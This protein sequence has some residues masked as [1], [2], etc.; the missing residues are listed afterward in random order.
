MTGGIIIG[1]NLQLEIDSCKEKI[2]LNSI[3]F[4]SSLPCRTLNCKS[5]FD[6]TVS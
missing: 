5:V 3:V 6:F 4:S 2:N 1:V